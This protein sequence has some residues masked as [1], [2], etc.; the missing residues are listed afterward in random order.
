M[1]FDTVIKAEAKKQNVI[2]LESLLELLNHIRI[3]QVS[4]QKPQTTGAR[5]PLSTV[6]QCAVSSLPGGG[7]FASELG[8]LS[9]GE[10]VCLELLFRWSGEVSQKGSPSSGTRSVDG[11]IL[12]LLPNRAF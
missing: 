8:E 12:V 6:G 7:R 2:N 10:A 5:E 3:F 11:S 1:I 9:G 4:L